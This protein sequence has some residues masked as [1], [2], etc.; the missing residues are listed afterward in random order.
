MYYHFKIHKEKKGF[1]AECVEIDGIFT[2]GRTR[3]ELYE[4]MQEALNLHMSEPAGSNIVFPCARKT[5][6][7]RGIVK[8][9]ANHSVV[10]ANELRRLRKEKGLTQTEA[11]EIM[12]LDHL[13]S[14]QRL[15]N[16]KSANPKLSTLIRIKEAFPKFPLDMLVYS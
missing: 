13:T 16:P 8:V 10:F 1:W 2:D 12:G 15:E 7:G 9:K 6:K 5:I 14:Y 4:N 3:D 11:K